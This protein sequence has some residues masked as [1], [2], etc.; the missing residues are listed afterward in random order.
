M[1]E[2]KKSLGTIRGTRRSIELTKRIKGMPGFAPE[3]IDSVIGEVV[4][5]FPHDEKCVYLQLEDG[6]PIL[7][8]E[9]LEYILE[10]MGREHNE[11]DYPF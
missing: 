11:K 2:E 10:V 7:D 8:K 4:F 3:Y 5:N 9:D 1:K 6:C